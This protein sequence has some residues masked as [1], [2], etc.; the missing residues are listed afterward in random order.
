MGSNSW[1]AAMP[2]GGSTYLTARAV[3]ADPRAVDAFG[4]L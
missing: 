3:A 4:E 1:T 2:A